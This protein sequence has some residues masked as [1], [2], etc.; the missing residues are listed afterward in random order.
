MLESILMRVYST[1]FEFALCFRWRHKALSDENETWFEAKDLAPVIENE[2][3]T[4]SNEDLLSAGRSGLIQN[5]M[6]EPRPR[7]VENVLYESGSEQGEA[8][9]DFAELQRPHDS[10]RHAVQ[11]QQSPQ[12]I[13]AS[14][15]YESIPIANVIDAP[16]HPLP[17]P[18]SQSPISY[19][20]MAARPSGMLHPMYTPF[21]RMW[22]NHNHSFNSA[23][24]PHP[25]HRIGLRKNLEQVSV[26][27]VW[28]YS[29]QSNG[30]PPHRSSKFF[31]RLQRNFPKLNHQR[32][33]QT[34][35][36]STIKQSPSMVSGT[37]S[38]PTPYA[39]RL[40][41]PTQRPIPT[42]QVGKAKPSPTPVVAKS[43]GVEKLQSPK[44]NKQIVFPQP[45]EIPKPAATGSKQPLM[46]R[47]LPPTPTA[48]RIGES[49]NNQGNYY[50][51]SLSM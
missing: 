39:E 15:T 19:H 16:G 20:H 34:Q 33:V 11:H 49:G 6:I 38:E 29:N 26:P 47:P 50:V 1:R 36:V 18:P 3:Y 23:L 24:S 46:P 9:N 48:E 45:Y 51:V 4:A 8:E 35:S 17:E 22:R 5:D 10:R 40:F 25:L 30:I 12:H 28:S 14:P 31:K 44:R 37:Y 41:T 42:R 2:A 27:C 32:L 43:Q 13:K 21:G 7:T